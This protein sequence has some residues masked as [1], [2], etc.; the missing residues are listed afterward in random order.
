MVHL[1]VQGVQ[2]QSLVREL[3]SGMPWQPRNQSIKQKK[4]CNKFNKD[5]KNS[6]HQGKN[7]KKKKKENADT[8]STGKDGV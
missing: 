3:G 1:P 7:S 6:P 4:Y 5:F 2:V 8:D